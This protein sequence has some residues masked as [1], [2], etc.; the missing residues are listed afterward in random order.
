MDLLVEAGY[1]ALHRQGG[2]DL[3]RL[4]GGILKA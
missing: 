4:G 1:R 2:G 3:T